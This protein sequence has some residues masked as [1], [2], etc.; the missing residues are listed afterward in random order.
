MVNGQAQ[1]DAP[2]TPTDDANSNARPV[3]FDSVPKTFPVAQES[4]D[5][6]DGHDVA[7]GAPDLVD[8]WRRT[9]VDGERVVSDRRPIR[10][11]HRLRPRVD[12]G[13]FVVE[14]AGT[15]EACQRHQVDMPLIGRVVTGDQARQHPGVGGLD[16]AADECQP[17]TGYGPH[18]ERL[19][20]GDVAVT[21]AQQDQVLDD[22]YRLH[23][24]RTPHS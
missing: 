1:F 3:L 5:G 21:A 20:Y 12:P 15:G 6:F 24:I 11:R 10:Q 8:R 14:E 23:W 22:R 9:G 7:A 18:A 17:D 2:R 16:I 13:D 4:V 19:E